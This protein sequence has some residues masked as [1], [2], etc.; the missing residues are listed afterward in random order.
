MLSQVLAALLLICCAVFDG[1]VVP[2]LADSGQPMARPLTLKRPGENLQILFY[3]VDGLWVSASCKND[4]THC[5][6]FQAA[7]TPFQKSSDS[8]RTRRS[9]IADPAAVNCQRDGG[10]CLT[11]W[12]IKGNQVGACAFG[13]KTLIDSWDLFRKQIA[14][15]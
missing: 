11:L 10:S 5:L 9:K 2:A 15:K 3:P 7:K 8:A 14:K 6:A 4:L 12:D 1:A 13:D